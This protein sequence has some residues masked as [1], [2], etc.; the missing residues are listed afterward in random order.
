[1]DWPAF[2]EKIGYP[3][4]VTLLV[5]YGLYKI[6][7]VYV[8]PVI[9]D[10]IK[11]GRANKEKQIV[12]AQLLHEQERLDRIRERDLFLAA[13]ASR[14]DM[15]KESLSKVVKA[16]DA[17]SDKIEAKKERKTVPR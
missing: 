17:L 3:A 13:M 9:S 2:V 7:T 6:F 15:M 10:A 1:M 12:Q 16:L 14:D 5:L 4:F 8:W 11:E